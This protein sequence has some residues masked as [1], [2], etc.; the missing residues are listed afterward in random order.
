MILDDDGL[1]NRHSAPGI[2]PL[3]DQAKRDVPTW[4]LLAC[5]FQFI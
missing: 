1:L 5:D 4:S 2:L 3:A